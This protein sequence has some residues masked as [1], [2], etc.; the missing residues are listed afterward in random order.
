[1]TNA[2]GQQLVT[3]TGLG[4]SMFSLYPAS[5]LSS[6]MCNKQKR[7]HRMRKIMILSVC[8]TM[9]QRFFGINFDLILICLHTTSTTHTNAKRSDAKLRNYPVPGAI[10]F[11]RFLYIVQNNLEPK[12]R[13]I[14]LL[15]YGLQNGLDHSEAWIIRFPF[16]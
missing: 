14:L 3:N 13:V 9:Q 15:S 6:N 5:L 8:A 4:F 12:S 2:Y 11:Y 1:M 10:L 16:V 7:K